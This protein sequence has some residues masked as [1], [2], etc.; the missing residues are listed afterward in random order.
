M[1]DAVE[2][3]DE[4]KR[5]ASGSG[6]AD[7]MAAMMA[8]RQNS[9]LPRVGEQAGTPQ[10]AVQAVGGPKSTAAQSIALSNK[11]RQE[12]RQQTVAG[13]KLEKE[14]S[15]QKAE[16]EKS[17]QV[18]RQ[19]ADQERDVA[20]TR[21]HEVATQ[22]QQAQGYQQKQDGASSGFGQSRQKK[23]QA[24][25]LRANGHQLLREAGEDPVKI[26]QALDLLSEAGFTAD[27]ADRLYQETYDVADQMGQDA[28]LA[29]LTADQSSGYAEAAG[30][31]A[32]GAEA[33]VASDTSNRDA[34]QATVDAGQSMQ[35]EAFIRSSE[36]DAAA[37]LSSSTAGWNFTPND[38]H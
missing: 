35:L 31:T 9:V 30:A 15:Q 32:S 12:A 34:A 26:Q 23:E 18:D 22:R 38:K 29:S 16:A 25:F 5:L 7:Q 37:D 8:I 10:D 1:A 33:Q 36:A 13:Q 21:E 24:A 2:A 4:K 28:A 14:G 27:Q 17:L 6:A 3:I 11:L 19:R 20:R